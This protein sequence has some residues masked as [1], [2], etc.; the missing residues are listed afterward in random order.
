MGDERDT[1]YPLEKSPVEQVQADKE[2]KEEDPEVKDL[3]EGISVGHDEVLNYVEVIVCLTLLCAVALWFFT[4]CR[5]ECLE[6][7]NWRDRETLK[8]VYSEISGSPRPDAV[9]TIEQEA[10]PHAHAK[11]SSADQ[12]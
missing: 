10:T 5:M 11:R 2:E 12:V 4:G 3:P 8:N 1:T 9:I 7:I 6:W